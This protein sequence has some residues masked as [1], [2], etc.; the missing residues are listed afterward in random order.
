MDGPLIKLFQ[1]QNPV[2][3]M[4][5]AAC[6]VL[7]TLSANCFEN[8]HV[9]C[10]NMKN[11]FMLPYIKAAEKVRKISCKYSIFNALVINR[12]FYD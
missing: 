6:D 1:S 7:S 8:L 10:V 2:F 5:A 12:N 3:K 11:F 9:S 4:L